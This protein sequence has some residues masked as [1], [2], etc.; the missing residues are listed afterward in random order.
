[1]SHVFT[2]LQQKLGE[3]VYA[4]MFA[5]RPE[6]IAFIFGYL[7]HGFHDL[8]HKGGVDLFKEPHVREWADTIKR[9]MSTSDEDAAHPDAK[10]LGTAN[11]RAR[12]LTYDDKRMFSRALWELY[13][14]T[15][16]FDDD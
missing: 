8:D 14:Y 15:L 1:M 12:R 9:Y 16:R 4:A 2:Y 5:E 10:Q 11:I 13:H 6:E 7:I 3:A